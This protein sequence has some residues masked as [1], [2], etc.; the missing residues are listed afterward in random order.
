[1]RVDGSVGGYGQT[2][3]TGIQECEVIQGELGCW[4]GGLGCSVVGIMAEE[5]GTFHSNIF[6]ICLL[7]FQRQADRQTGR[8]TDTHA[9]SQAGRQLSRQTNLNTAH[10]LSDSLCCWSLRPCVVKVRRGSL[11]KGT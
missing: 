10:R 7:R 11:Q 1:M 9:G 2:E 3:G 8:Q 6:S 5:T 4:G